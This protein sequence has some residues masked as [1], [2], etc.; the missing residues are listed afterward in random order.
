MSFLKRVVVLLYVTLAMFVG[1]FFLLSAVDLSYFNIYV[2]ENSMKIFYAIYSDESLKL[3]FGILSAIFLVV[4]F[5]F[6]RILFEGRRKEDII[7]FDNPDGRVSVALNALEDLVKRVIAR[8]TEVKEVKSSIKVSPKGL[9][10]QMRLTVTSEV[11]IP[12][13]TSHV[14]DIIKQK[15]QDIIGMDEKVIV[16][17][18]VEKILSEHFSEKISTE[19]PVAEENK[20]SGIPFQGY[21]A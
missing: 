1:W 8:R 10:V 16:E 20:E 7:A 9:K 5:V 11:S 6:Y 18:H 13:V 2:A 21:R 4:N 15:I 19:K 3:S 17:I 14:Q 12:E